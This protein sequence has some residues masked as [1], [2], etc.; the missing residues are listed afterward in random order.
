M[1]GLA[2]VGGHLLSDIPSERLTIS[3][4]FR[5]RLEILGILPDYIRFYLQKQIMG[6]TAVDGSQ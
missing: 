4:E 3:P 2:F 1:F 5:E 6:T